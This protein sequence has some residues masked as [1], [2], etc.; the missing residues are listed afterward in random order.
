MVSVYARAC[1]SSRDCDSCCTWLGRM[2]YFVYIA[3]RRAHDTIAQGQGHFL[4][5]EAGA[6]SGERRSGGRRGVLLIMR[7]RVRDWRPCNEGT[8]CVRL[9][10]GRTPGASGCSRAV[11][12]V[13]CPSPRN[14]LIIIAVRHN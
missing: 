13:R 4:E 7:G 11:R 1:Q 9:R 2:G 12:V 8:W 10:G 6:T 3:W 14:L 5:L